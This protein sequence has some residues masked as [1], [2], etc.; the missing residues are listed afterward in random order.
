[1]SDCNT[2]NPTKHA[3]C[4]LQLFKP[5]ATVKRPRFCGG[6]LVER[7]LDLIAGVFFDE[8]FI[9]SVNFWDLPPCHLCYRSVRNGRN[10]TYVSNRWLVNGILFTEHV[11]KISFL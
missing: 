4:R 3:H 5:I 10:I 8:I 2:T 9:G 11:V 7:Y 1:M 6:Q